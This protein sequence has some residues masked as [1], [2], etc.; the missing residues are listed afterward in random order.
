MEITVEISTRRPISK[1]ISEPITYAR[2][3]VNL[4]QDRQDGVIV[5]TPLPR[6][7]SHIYVVRIFGGH[8]REG[9]GSYSCRCSDKDMC[10]GRRE[11]SRERGGGTNLAA[12][13]VAKRNGGVIR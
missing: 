9:G 10:D 5:I 2:A 6:D 1:P 7:L 3:L 12:C 11:D 13:L 8:R 4:V